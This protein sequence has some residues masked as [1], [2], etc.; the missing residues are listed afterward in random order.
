[1]IIDS[2]LAPVTQAHARE[3]ARAES[4]DAVACSPT[5]EGIQ[6]IARLWELD[7]TGQPQAAIDHAIVGDTGI[8]L[9][10]AGKSKHRSHRLRRA[11][12]WSRP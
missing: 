11:P 4:R 9:I 8:G 1:M 3:L 10:E 12:R 2:T 7:C 6:A 5:A